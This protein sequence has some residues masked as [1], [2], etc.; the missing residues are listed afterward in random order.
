MGSSSSPSVLLRLNNYTVLP[1]ASEILPLELAI[2]MTVLEGGLFCKVTHFDCIS[3][4]QRVRGV[5]RIEKAIDT[6]K[7]LTNWVKKYVGLCVPHM[8]GCLIGA[9][10]GQS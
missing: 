7:R 9:S 10:L 5:P 2:A 6:N 4:L 3:Q 1:R 8:V